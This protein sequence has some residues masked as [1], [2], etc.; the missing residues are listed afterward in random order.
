[1]ETL[2]SKAITKPKLADVV[3]DVAAAAIKRA[4]AEPDVGVGAAR[5][6]AREVA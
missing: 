5:T 2:M 3:T 6:V 1:M 4:A